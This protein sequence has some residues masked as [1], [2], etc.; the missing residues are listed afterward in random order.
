MKNTLTDIFLDV[1]AIEA[2]SGHEKP[3]ADYIRQFCAR[4][5]LKVEED[6]THKQFGGNSGNLICRIGGGGDIALLSHMDTARSTGGLKPQ[7][8]S[9]R[10]TSDGTT[11]LGVDNRAGIAVI[12][13]TLARVFEEYTAPPGFTIAFT[14]CE[15]TTLIGSKHLDLT[16]VEMAFI[17]DSALRPGNFIRQSYGAQRFDITVLGKAAHSGLAPENGINAIKTAAMAINDFSV[18]R[19][20]AETT[21]NIATIHGGEAL[22]VVPDRVRIEGE[23]RS[24]KPARVLEQVATVKSSFDKAVR[25]TGSSFEFSSNWEFEPYTITSDL[26]VYRRIHNAIQQAGLEPV[27][28]ISAGGSDANYLNAK[29]MPAIN[30]GIGAQNPH[31]N[32]EF[33]LLEDLESTARI[34]WALVTGNRS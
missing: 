33:I 13:Y 9:D 25:S 7:I 3:V 16:P 12:L 10:I 14:I 22:N 2:L 8:H 19:V 26:P 29:N 4:F 17:F 32:D 1:A 24:L 18:G 28:A 5:D 15:E 30:I 31:A 34:A 11:V 20:D 27:E 6:D 21:L 23:V